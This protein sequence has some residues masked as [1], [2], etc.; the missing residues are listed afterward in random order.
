[1]STCHS[2]RLVTIEIWRRELEHPKLGDV[3]YDCM[4]GE[5]LFDEY[6]AAVV[7]WSKE[8]I[9]TCCLSKW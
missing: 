7:R 4:S 6:A 8:V 2:S 9:C 3:W 1:M 5:G